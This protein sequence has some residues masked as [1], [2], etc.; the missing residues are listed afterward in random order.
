MEAEGKGAAE[1]ETLVD[2]EFDQ[3]YERLK[4]EEE[5]SAVR[6]AGF[7]RRAGAF[8]IDALVLFLFSLL[9]V[10]LASVAYR[11]GLAAHQRSLSWQTMPPLFRILAV[12]WIFLVCGYFV[13]LHGL[14][15]R[16][17]G[18]WLFGLRVVGARQEP[19]TYSQALVRWIGAL[20]IS[21]LLVGFLRILWNR[22]KRGWHDLMA[23]TWVI[24]ERSS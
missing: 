15:G 10:Y 3:L 13:L 20:A 4:R 17:V 18:K 11:V 6:W 2:R 9:L 1:L 12:A 8:M 21:P 23:R 22:E 7:F 24:R 19:I 16:T 14:E 5:A